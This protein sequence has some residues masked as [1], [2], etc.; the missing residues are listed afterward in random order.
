LLPTVQYAYGDES[1][2]HAEARYCVVAGYIGAPKAW[3]SFASEWKA[4]LKSE[5][6]ETGF[7]TR[8]F[9]HGRDEYEGWSHEKRDRLLEALVNVIMSHEVYPNGCAVNVRDYLSLPDEQQHFFTG[10]KLQAGVVQRPTP[11]SPTGYVAEPVKAMMNER[12]STRLYHVAALL[13]LKRAIESAPEDCEL[14]AILASL[15]HLSGGVFA[16]SLSDEY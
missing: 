8:R 11:L 16:T 5:G 14:H 4:A 3:E 6:V 2:T 12:T 15:E 13:F 9:L 1:G 7:H 10:D